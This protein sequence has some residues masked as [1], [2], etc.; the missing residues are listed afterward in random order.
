MSKNVDEEVSALK[1][2]GA[3]DSAWYLSTYPD[4]QMLKM[5]P[6][7]HYL[8][9][10]RLIGRAP[11]PDSSTVERYLASPSI[12]IPVPVPHRVDPAECVPH[13]DTRESGFDARSYSLANPDLRHLTG[14]HQLFEH[15]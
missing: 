7:E 4:V 1:E 11:N 12:K 13:A 2:S 3:F 9:I 8:R 15:W 14:A 6:A 10:G 5:D